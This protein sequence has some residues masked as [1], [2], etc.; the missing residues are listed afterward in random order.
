[1]T[2][3]TDVLN[4]S[5]G[6]SLGLSDAT[7]TVS[8]ANPP[9]ATADNPHGYPPFELRLVPTY[10]NRQLRHYHVSGAMFDVDKEELKRK[11]DDRK[12]ILDLVSWDGNTR[13]NTPEA[14]TSLI[15]SSPPP[16]PH[17]ISRT[18]SFNA[19]SEEDSEYP[20]PPP[21]YRGLKLN[22]TTIPLLKY[23]SIIAQFNN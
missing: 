5:S 10:T 16:P 21:G 13:D 4:P 12:E 14:S 1:M 22:N 19:N 23:T 7:P 8:G 11:M 20:K 9:I 15:S 2:N 6:N 17:S 3:L 18:L